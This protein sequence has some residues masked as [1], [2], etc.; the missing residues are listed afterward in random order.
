VL[1]MQDV[2]AIIVLAV[3]PNISNPELLPL[4]LSVVKGF[5]S[6]RGRCS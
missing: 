6:S 2:L 4:G 1:L 3:Q 5:A